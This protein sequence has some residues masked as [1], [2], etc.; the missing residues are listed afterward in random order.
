MCFPRRYDRPPATYYLPHDDILI[1]RFSS[2]A[3]DGVLSLAFS[4]D[5]KT[6][7]VAGGV[8]GDAKDGGKTSGEM[9]LIPLK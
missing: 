4:S 2:T 7:A 9:R 6:L 3:A 5:G 1:H 8:A